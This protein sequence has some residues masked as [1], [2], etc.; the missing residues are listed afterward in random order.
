MRAI[1][2]RQPGGP[3]VLELIECAEPRAGVG[4][5]LIAV[6]ASGLNRPDLLQRR[7]LYPPPPGV[8]ELPGLEV[9]GRILDGDVQALRAAGLEIGRAVVALVAG[10]G[11]AERCVA[12]VAQCLPL[13]TGWTMEEGAGLPETFFTVWSNLFDQ[14]GLKAGDVVL[15]H[16]GSSGIGT[17]AIQ[18]ARCFGARVLVTVG[19]ESKAMA[20]HALG[21]ELA[22][23]YREQ[24]FVA[25]VLDATGQRGADLILDMVGGPY[26]NRDLRCLA[27]DGRVQLI[28][29]QGGTQSEVDA[30]LLL[31]RRLTVAG[32]T[33]RAR[34]PAFKAAIA[35]QLRDKVWPLMEARR[36]RPVM[37]QSFAA[38]D[39][40]RAHETLEAGVHVG[41]LVLSWN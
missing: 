11:Y 38:A 4:E 2:I 12:P 5:C 23:N 13:P 14:A 10:G 35:Q 27:E 33:L 18:L 36:V 40:V 29:V 15:V 25:A 21:A 7:G 30:G 17:T 41:K 20:C 39:V 16:G 24:D 8:S 19:S 6:E 9:A 28:A 26:L 3:E 34:S 37:A 31:R 1:A 22:I 32:S